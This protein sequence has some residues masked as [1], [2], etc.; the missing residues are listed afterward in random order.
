MI[1]E[2]TLAQAAATSG[3]WGQVSGCPG[4]GIADTIQFAATLGTITVTS[5]LPSIADT[6]GTV[7]TGVDSTVQLTQT[8]LAAG[9]DGLTLA[10][11]ANKITAMI[12]RN[13]PDA[14]IVVASNSNKLFQNTL[15]SNATGVVVGA[16]TGLTLRNNLITN[17]ST[18]GVS[19]GS[20]VGTINDNGYFSN[21]G[22]GNVHCT[23][24]CLIGANS[25]KANPRYTTPGSN[26]SLLASSPAINRGI[27][28]VADQPDM[29][30]TGT[31]G[32]FNSGAPDMGAR[33][34]SFATP[35]AAAS[36]LAELV[37]IT[38]YYNSTGIP[39]TWNSLPTIGGTNSGVDRIA[40]TLPSGFTS[41]SVTSVVFSGTTLALGG[42]NCSTAP[43]LPDTG[44]YCTSISGSVLT[45]T[46]GLR[47]LDTATNKQATISLTLSV[48]TVIGTG[49]FVSTVDDVMTASA[50]ITATAGNANGTSG[51]GITDNDTL[52]VET[53]DRVIVRNTGDAVNGTTS[54]AWML[55]PFPGT[56][57]ISLREAITAT[58]VGGAGVNNTPI[59]EI[60]VFNTTIFP[61]NGGATITP[62]SEFPALVDPS[63]TIIDAFTSPYNAGVT[64]DG[65]ALASTVRGLVLSSSNSIV[66]N[67]SFRN[68]GTGVSL[69]SGFSSNEVSKNMINNA[70]V[71]GILIDGGTSHSIKENTVVASV[72]V[73]IDTSGSPT[74]VVIRDNI[75]SSSGS[76][77]I[78]VCCVSPTTNSVISNQ[79][80]S[81]LGGGIILSGGSG[82]SIDSNTV[83][84]NTGGISV[85]GGSTTPTI[86]KN[87][88]GE[89]TGIGILIGTG[90]TGSTVTMNT[91]RNS[92]GDGIQ[93][94]ANTGKIFHNTVN[95][96]SGDGMEVGALVSSFDLR[97][98]ISSN[99]TGGGINAPFGGTVNYNDFFNNTGGTCIGGCTV[100][101]NSITTD[102]LYISP[103]SPTY[104]FHL[105]EPSSPAINAGIDLGTSQPDLNGTGTGNY[106][107]VAPDMGAFEST[108]AGAPSL[109]TMTVSAAT[110]I[111]SVGGS[112]TYTVNFTNTGGVSSNGVVATATLASGFTFLSGS[113]SI[114]G[115]ATRSPA[116]PNPTGGESAPQW[117]TFSIPALSGGVNG[118]LV[119]TFRAAIA[120]SVTGGAY[121]TSGSAASTDT[122]IP[123]YN[124]A[125]GT[126]DDVTVAVGNP[127]ITVNTITD[128]DVRNSVLT[129]REAILLAN[130]T[131]TTQQL[132][133]AE[134]VQIA[135]CV[136]SGIRE[137]INFDGGIFPSGTPGIIAIS[138]SSLPSLTDASGVLLDAF[139]KGVTVDGVA[140]SSGVGLTLASNTNY[141]RDFTIKRF[142]GTGANGV[143]ILLSS[144]SSNTL[145]GLT[146]RDH[147]TIGV[148]VS[149]GTG[150]SLSTVTSTLNGTL[151]IEITGG[152][153]S[154]TSNTVTSNS[155][156]GIKV[157]V[158]T[159]N[160]I[161]ASTISSNTGI[162][163]ELVSSSNSL[164]GSTLNAN[165]TI[166]V[167]ISGTST[168]V[169]TNTIT[170]SGTHGLSISGSTNTS[171]SSNT[172]TGST[173]RGLF[174][175]GSS[176][177]TTGNTINTNT[178]GGILI[179]T[180]T[181]NTVTGGTIN[182]N[183]GPGVRIESNSNTISSA[184]VSS[185]GAGGAIVT[186][187]LNTLTSLT[188]ATNTGI[189]VELTGS[190]TT[191]S[192]STITAP[193]SYGVRV[194]TG[195]GNT[196][197]S[198]TIDG[199]TGAGVRLESASNTLSGGTVMNTVTGPGV[200]VTG[201]AGNTI[202]TVSIRTNAG[203]GV[204]LTGGT[205]AII[206][207]NRIATNNPGA[208]I[209][210]EAAATGSA[211]HVNTINGNSGN[212]VTIGANSTTLF[213]NTVSHNSGIG[214]SIGGAV[215][216]FDLRNNQFTFNTG[217]SINAPAGGTIDYN[218]TYGN[219]PSGTCGGG[220]TLGA[221]ATKA[222]PRYVSPGTVYTSDFSLKS[223]SS[224]INRG[225]DLAPSQPDLNG[226]SAGNFNSTAPDL[227]AVE[228]TFS[229][230]SV[231]TSTQA[232]LIPITVYAGSSLIPFVWDSQPG[233]SSSNSGVDR[234]NL[235]LPAGY[236]APAATFVTVSGTALTAGSANCTPAFLPEPTEYCST[237]SGSA[238]SI[239][240]GNRIIDT[241][242][243]KKI[244]VNF[245]LTVP[246]V[247]DTGLTFISNVD[248]QMTSSA[249]V[250]A[251]AA[252]LNGVAANGITDNDT[253]TVIT[254]DTVMISNATEAVN[255]NTG[256]A[257][258]LVAYP[259][260][261]GISLREALTAVNAGQSVGVIDTIDFNPSIFPVATP[262]VITITSALPTI[263]DTAATVISAL[264][265]PGVPITLPAG[266]IVD[267]TSAG[268]SVAGLTLTTASN[269]LLGFMV[270]NF[271]GVGVAMGSG[272][273][274][275]LSAMVIASNAGG[276]ITL[277]GNSAKLFQNTINNSAT[278][279]SVSVGVTGLDLR[280]NLITNNATAGVSAEAT[281]GTIDY[282]GYFNNGGSGNVHCAGGCAM[283][284]N[285]IKTDP[286]YTNT[287]T[288]DFSLLSSSTAVNRGIDLLSNQPDMNGA[289][290]GS[291]DSTAPDMGAR[292]SSFSVPAVATSAIAELIPITVYASST[293]I[294]FTWDSQP[295][296]SSS[297]SGVDRVLL[298]LP[299]GY[300][301][302]AVTGVTVSGSVMTFG[303]CASA[304]NLPDSNEYCS[305]FTSPTLTVTFGSRVLDTTS[306]KRIT[307]S[308]TMS[309]PSVV[310]SG[311]VFTVSV[312]DALTSSATVGA[313][314]GNLNGVAANGVT[315]NDTLTVTTV[316][317]VRVSNTTDTANGSTGSAGL[318]VAAPGTDGI[319]LREALAAVGAGA[320]VGVVD[321]ID[322]LS[323][324]GTITVTG[325]PLP[326]VTDT[327]GTII[328]AVESTV[329]VTQT[330]LAAG[331]DGLTIT[332]GTANKLLG[333]IVRGFPDAGI[334]ITG[335]TNKLFHNTLHANGTG[336]SVG[337]GV[338]GLDFRNNLITNNTVV[339]VSAAGTV[340]T[341]DYNGYFSNGGSGN[342]HCTGG[343]SIGANSM[344]ANPRY[345]NSAAFDFS[346]L[347]SSPAINRGLD[348]VGD[349]P[350]MN[351]LSAGTFNS[352]A[353]DMGARESSFA[354]P[355][356]ATSAISELI[357]MTVYVNSTAVPFTW[358]SQPTISSIQ[359]GVD[360]VLLTFPT[361]Y[362]SP[363]VT[364]VTVSG[365]AMTAGSCAS[366]P[367]LPDNN[368]Y[369]SS[370]SGSVL[371]VTFGSRV[372]DT[373]SNKRITVALT[374]NVPS[375]GDSGLVFTVS[376]DD[377]LTSSA[378]VGATAGNAN[379]TVGN[380]VTDNDTL[381]VT[382]IGTVRVSNTTD[383]V[384]GDTGSAGLLIAAPGSDGISLR[385]ALAAV[386]SGESVN[387][388]DT[389]DF[390]S[391]L[392][393]I[394]VSGSQLP[395]ITDPAG[396]II[397]A[398]GSTVQVTQTG[399][400]AGSD[401]L[402]ITAGTAN[403]LLGLIVRGFPDAGIVI[404][405]G[406]NKL[407]HNTL[408]AN[409]TGLSVGIGVTGLD[410]RNNLITNNTVVGVSAA[411]TVGTID[412]NGYFSNGGSGNVHCTGGCSIGANSMKANPRYTNSAAFDFSLLASSPA[413]N[414]GLDLVGDQPDMNGL[415]AGTFNSTAP[416]MGAR[417]S[418][419]AVPAVATSAISELIPMT[420]YVNS[421]AVPFTWDSQPTIS[422]IQSG[423]DRV[424]LTFPTGYASPAVTGVTVSGSAMT[425]GSCASAPNLP[426]NNEYCSSLSGS[427]LTVTFGS[428][429]LDT[430]SNKR[431]TVAL[432][433]NVPSTGDSGLVFTV[434]V[435]DA[436]TSSATVG[437]TAGNANTTVG[438]GVTDNDTLTVTTIGTVRVSNTTDVVNGD[439]GSA[440]LLIAAPGSDGISLREALAAVGS[441]ESVNVIDTIDFVSGLGTITVSGS[442]LPSITD[443]AGTI[444][445]AVGSTVQV[446]QFSL[447]AG[448]DGLTITAGAAN[449]IMGLIIR[450]FP[451][452]GIAITGGTGNKLF[453][454]TLHGNGTGL[455]VESGATGLNLKNNLITNNTVAGIAA[456]STAGAIDYNGYFSNGGSGNVH[457]TGG[458]SIGANSIKANPRYTGSPNFV[459]LASSPAIN[460]G[461]DLGADQPNMNGASVG[462]FDSTAPD[463]GARESS[464]ATP[465]VATSAISELIPITVYYNSTGIPFTWDSQPTISSSQSGVD[466][467]LLT[468]PVGYSAPAM[469]GVTVSGASLIA[470]GA[471]TCTTAPNLPDD[472]EYCSSF[473]GSTLT[474][475]FGSRVL[476]TTSN[477][478][479]M[480]SLTL[481]VPTV[482]DS[483]K[484][485]TVSVD[486]AMTSSATVGATAGNV[487]G[488][489]ANG[490]TDNDTLTVTTVNTVRVSNTTDTA[491]GNTGSAG[492]LVSNP[493]TDGISL[494]EAMTAINAGASI[495]VLD[496]IDFNTTVFPVSAPA[497]ITPASAL[498]V[499]SDT[500][501]AVISALNKTASPATAPAGVILSGAS[502][503]AG[504]G[505]A[506]T[507]GSNRV[508]G[509]VIYGF[510]GNGISI[511]GGSGSVIES[512][513]IRNNGGVGVSV[514]GSGH[515]LFHLT[516]HGHSGGIS[517]SDGTLEV[518]NSLITSNSSYG[519][520][521]PA[522]SIDYSGFFGNGSNC[523]GGCAIGAASIPLDPLYVNAAAGDFN[524]QASSPMINMGVDLGGSQPDQNGA[525]AGSYDGNFPD[526]GRYESTTGTTNPSVTIGKTAAAPTVNGGGQATYT[527][528]LT[529][530]GNRGARGI[531]VTD[532]LPSGFTYTST[533]ATGGLA[534]RTSVTDPAASSGTPAWSAWYIPPSGG[535]LTLTFSATATAPQGIYNNT[536]SATSIDVTITTFVGAPIEVLGY[537]VSGVVFLDSNKNGVPDLAEAGIVS[538]TVEVYAMPGNTLTATQTT[539]ASGN[540][541]FTGVANGTY[542]IR[543]TIPANYAATTPTILA[544]TINNAHITGQHFGNFAGTKITGT[545]F[546]DTGSGGGVANNGTRE[547]PESG[548]AAVSVRVTDVGGGTVYDQTTSSLTGSYTLWVPTT[549]TISVVVRE[550]NLANYTSTTPGTI[551]L[552]AAPGGTPANNNFGS[553]PPLSFS[554]NGIQT[555]RPGGT[556]VYAHILTAGTAGQ[557]TLV[558]VTSKGLIWTFYKDTN[559]NAQL[560]NGEPVLTAA[561]LNLVAS[562]TI[563][564]LMRAQIPTSL[565]IGIVDSTEV[566][567]TQALV[568]S[569]LTDIRKA[570]NLTT[571]AEGDLRLV[572]SGSVTTA[573]PG[574]SVIYTVTYMNTGSQPLTAIIV[575][576]RLSEFLLFVTATPSVDAGFPDTA[577]LL[578]W[579]IPGSL[580][581]G[582]SGSVSYT[583]TVK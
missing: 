550:T 289:G 396:T 262:G 542:E 440:G 336:L 19:A 163:V 510:S 129:L 165:T 152:T 153:T 37:P 193:T 68:F 284:G 55:V 565:A 578:R 97:N 508:S 205:G 493:G 293:L 130:G 23:G 526:F 1:S 564:I 14:A 21:G 67:L 316:N 300:S 364:G 272:A 214:V 325:S 543:E 228:S 271:S 212:G 187:N 263:S 221:N 296:I 324:L 441:G 30:G 473:S 326:S 311:K 218:N 28:L 301:A 498:P 569:S 138:G 418:S 443:P 463:M 49:T 434:S 302:P 479:I 329:Q 213:N 355:A 369:C 410:F 353:P 468:L 431:I 342:V 288:F 251:T 20:G 61:A 32:N 164:T 220:C 156:G 59:P 320:S 436:L 319:S 407:F 556:A 31:G 517:N 547:G 545:V 52:A 368:E 378:T 346:L 148:F 414:R 459:L 376:V 111:A 237:V 87:L 54:S 307:V 455:I 280:N 530:S 382:T 134:Q 583:V 339:G 101:A 411:G 524:L 244:T 348:L 467:V 48:P 88:V 190:T 53:V 444:I 210:I 502:A 338:T 118:R 269:R 507:S 76:A 412:Y 168:T 3:E 226:G 392:G 406:T 453:H 84:A 133:S 180:G 264:N 215:I 313:T 56:D 454:N 146:S 419:F 36:A 167:S 330:G 559:G 13:F 451:D 402:T 570:T 291:F 85:S 241:T 432:T 277:G 470:G 487:N 286:R 365:S 103:A 242:A 127:V 358:D 292:E 229:T 474:V 450:D 535:T 92:T 110:P 362:A 415:S 512:S 465:S 340:G 413:I 472:D 78:R 275:E 207:Y 328:T 380:G 350:D 203:D 183:T 222:D 452:A 352:T 147:G 428:R 492:L 18:A 219:T 555:V 511:L 337:I 457:C 161:S 74:S 157:S 409:G 281:V 62:G 430:T 177:T 446:T 57:G 124:G 70:R 285:S 366:A 351:G 282:N 16:V 10:A 558:A 537:N 349:Q 485:F 155:T 283:G 197:S 533:S 189:G 421:T 458:C 126:L 41:P 154:V 367:N 501:G 561:D 40:L 230:P 425:A 4:V 266:V 573:K 400:A 388:I 12:V 115:N 405:G 448:S 141:L 477:K 139:G 471:A 27:D 73:G 333:L 238:F 202:D 211:I 315:D 505:I 249:T 119:I 476:D 38:V 47:I 173:Q 149:G 45:I 456:G 447:A 314:A 122:T 171:V 386:G 109:V 523:T 528:T 250:A 354:V 112:A 422:S 345:T 257:G 75:V 390:V 81:N 69:S 295:T 373:T 135:G 393:T 51:N 504:A 182:S 260:T 195:T 486:D 239:I 357:P 71:T 108:I 256:S 499:L 567:A 178:A 577:G 318:L 77:G 170:N 6:A 46:S 107:G 445:T 322:F 496:T 93:I 423:V 574:D 252:N 439:T 63:G 208:G 356:V 331:S 7:I 82:N 538:V 539:N 15:Y 194:I 261:E 374:L 98:N 26:F 481:T 534:T 381:T 25:I 188:M 125:T 258:L 181:G 223:S 151:G 34:S 287:A 334:V 581:G 562:Q 513:L 24:G 460:R 29:N 267:G 240:F 568:N 120:C 132:T 123:S 186:G 90:S 509:L 105:E 294:P 580:G 95:G 216:G 536:V 290:A 80:S 343:C 116:T 575:Y 50:A 384:N 198:N 128:G 494:R 89:T 403:K 521:S 426:D 224:S 579:T 100:G 461:I 185:N 404:T 327:A 247:E 113:T 144:A 204:S 490:V 360:R 359:S 91:A 265:K 35:A 142:A 323:G 278:G 464:F 379:T 150:N 298:T 344:K 22:T 159:G 395:S 255:G 254:V 303:S 478:R 529:N 522:A 66:R 196:I 383:V 235:T 519:I 442:Q 309:V 191:L 408:H 43:N 65:T 184:A 429:V 548:M 137:T 172:I 375:T 11:G 2:G 79:V 469:T 274:N 437:A 44:E 398:V 566:T 332:A 246:T 389:I 5:V 317:T 557:V 305:S 234:V 482:A 438:N 83:L 576:D 541:L 233:M 86:T 518:K 495:G 236:S 131:L 58:Q 370:L 114:S 99:N 503:G 391:G 42:A 397:T 506:M 527:I 416:D 33:E 162:G 483:G 341:I 531:A 417:E 433:L 554:P 94:L 106:N 174:I 227:G 424:L 176:N 140:L 145:T 488:V 200:A 117:G 259:G 462:N 245:T 209:N 169:T 361:G 276:G 385:E 321:T 231:A 571:V 175:T 64:I 520:S 372:L 399:L 435:D 232:E 449:K 243:N 206:K 387:V 516:V 572:K 551:S 160:T 525:T 104:D 484:L 121:H 96:N 136:G 199:A 549:T 179:Q 268:A 475:M 491:N 427:V 310:D 394:T 8:G 299:A 420:V 377:A 248:D 363:A 552:S 158:G 279:L 308:L 102:P 500:G 515:K 39:F 143:G 9:S 60:I 335:G 553:V 306:N 201:G 225:L 401:G 497:T 253:L 273:S 480:V 270:R 466:R 347:A 514:S 217:A 192:S 560:E 540:Y 166:G 297:Q 72:G 563:K 532:T 544:V 546:L 312:D 17:N 371:T 582:A 489:A 304:P